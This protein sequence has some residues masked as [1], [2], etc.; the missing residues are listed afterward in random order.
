MPAAMGGLRYNYRLR[1]GSD[2]R[3][4]ILRWAE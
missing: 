3:L 1:F 2:F 4:T